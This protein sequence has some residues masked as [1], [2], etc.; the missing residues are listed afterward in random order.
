VIIARTVVSTAG[1]PHPAL[2]NKIA[3]PK[4][5]TPAAASEVGMRGNL[6]LQAKRR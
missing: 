3:L 4:R 5:I 1:D 6:E 2:R